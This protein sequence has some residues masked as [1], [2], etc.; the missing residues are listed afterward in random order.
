MLVVLNWCEILRNNLAEKVTW[1]LNSNS[2]CVIST[3]SYLRLKVVLGTYFVW[4]YL[5]YV[6]T[7]NKHKHLVGYVTFKS[8][9]CLVSLIVHWKAGVG[10]LSL[11]FYF[12]LANRIITSPLRNHEFPRGNGDWKSW[13]MGTATSIRWLTFPTVIFSLFFS[14]TAAL[15][16]LYLR[17]D[18]CHQKT[19]FCGKQLADVQNRVQRKVDHMK[20]FQGLTE[21]VIFFYLIFCRYHE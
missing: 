5:R 1:W 18:L 4:P 6:G 20:A 13:H 11:A 19:W 21:F 12:V 3:H 8:F 15:T 9:E 14:V 10:S 17:T 7:V 2:A 16:G